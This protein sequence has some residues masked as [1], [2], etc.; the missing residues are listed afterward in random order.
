LH[1]L[2]KSS[3]SP[4]KSVLVQKDKWIAHF[5]RLRWK[6][7]VCNLQIEK[8]EMELETQNLNAMILR[9]S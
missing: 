3:I 4:T 9:V 8:S 1:K 6:I 5:V 7:N 2:Y